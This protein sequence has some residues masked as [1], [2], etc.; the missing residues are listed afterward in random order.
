MCT[1][2]FLPLGDHNFI[3]T[4][5]RD[6]PYSRKSALAPEIYVENGVELYYPKDGEAGGTWIGTSEKK[7]LVCLLN[8]GYK[9]HE[10]Q[11]SYRKSR[12]LVVKDVLEADEVYEFLKQV[13]LLD[14]EPFTLIV[15]DWNDTLE[16]VEFVWT[17][18]KKHYFNI[19]K[20]PQIWSSSTLYDE[21]T[22]KLRQ[23]WFQSWQSMTA[24]YTRESILNFHKTAGNGNPRQNVLMKRD[25]GGTVSISSVQ[26]GEKGQVDF[27]YEPIPR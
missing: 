7:R 14:I 25:G 18:K 11:S 12:G 2:T 9:D 24:N 3:F 1:A 20:Q 23:E 26:L 10:V 16:L 19:P 17:G 15:V 6:I 22:K 27:Y 5:S 4:S 8:G 13:D 21:E